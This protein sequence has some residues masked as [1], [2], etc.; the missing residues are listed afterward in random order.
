MDWALGEARKHALLRDAVITSHGDTLEILL[1]DGRTFGFRP[2]ALI[3]GRAPLRVR[4]ELLR[5]LLEIGVR[6]AEFPARAEHT[7]AAEHT[8]DGERRSAEEP[9]AETETE[10][11]SFIPGDYFS[12]DE[13]AFLPL[14]RGADYFLSSHDDSD[15]YVYVPLTD[16]IAVGVVSAQDRP[17]VENSAA[18][19]VRPPQ[20]LRYAQLEEG[21]GEVREILLQALNTL[22]RRTNS[23]HHSV[24]LGVT[25]AGG[26]K[27]MV[28]LQPEG[29]ELSWFC[30][31][32]TAEQVKIRAEEENG[33]DIVLFVPVSNTKLYVVFAADPHL[34]DFFRLLL[35]QRESPEAVYPL[36]HTL[37]ADGWQEWVPLPGTPLAE[38]LGALRNSFRKKI[39]DVQAR[40]MHRWGDF[41][42]VKDFEERV[43]EDGERVS[44]TVWSS[45]DGVGSIPETDFITFVRE[46]SPHPWEDGKTA[47]ISLRLTVAREVW[48]DGFAADSNFWPPRW[49]VTGFPDEEELEKLKR[50]ATRRF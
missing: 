28:F 38:T 25:T 4:E 1:G 39:Y 23:Y 3:D 27:I 14:V 7:F 40:Q 42:A 26:A 19:P 17:G 41:G 20:P 2:G 45:L 13:Q 5:R 9:E 46:A 48:P 22:R 34:N 29:Y 16:F 18:L 43:L 35:E 36:P 32:E 44:N 33:D 12:P 31:V 47:R 6:N 49:K 10:E 37:A 15:S 11:G 8:P 24:D 21:G 30:D 50:A